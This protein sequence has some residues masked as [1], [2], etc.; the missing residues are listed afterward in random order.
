MS[1]AGPATPG[2]PSVL[3][4]AHTPESVGDARR[5]VVASLDRGG[6]SE[7]LVE[8]SALVLSEL[9]TNAVRHARPL[10]GGCVEIVWWSDDT[11]VMLRIRDGGAPTRP[12]VTTASMAALGGRGL[13]IV[14]ALA[15]EWGVEQV[16][17]STVVWAH[18]RPTHTSSRSLP[19]AR[20]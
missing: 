17:G 7:G 11:G 18:L 14:R 3:T 15:P 10:P 4:L 9:F 1:T 20:R 2:R 8:E 6:V 13:G 16:D 5:A 12:R 19:H